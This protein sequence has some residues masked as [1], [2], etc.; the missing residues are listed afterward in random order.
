[1]TDKTEPTTT[2]SKTT[3]LKK[4][5]TQKRKLQA[6]K[7]MQKQDKDGPKRPVKSKKKKMQPEN[8]YHEPEELNFNNAGKNQIMQKPQKIKHRK[9]SPIKLKLPKMPPSSSMDLNSLSMEHEG[10][11]MLPPF[12]QYSAPAAAMMASSNLIPQLQSLLPQTPL[13]LSAIAAPSP[14]NYDLTDRDSV[15]QLLSSRG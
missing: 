10:N 12:Q 3:G 13:P 4:A 6:S 7:N 5:G 15:R 2:K 1:M 14:A 11:A 8:G 9:K